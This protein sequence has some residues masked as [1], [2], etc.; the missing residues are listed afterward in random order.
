[1]FNFD[2]AKVQ[3]FRQDLAVPET[4]PSRF[5]ISYVFCCNIAPIFLYADMGHYKCASQ[6]LLP[7]YI[8]LFD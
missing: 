7:S 5:Q 1:M 2:E 4:L 3:C 6:L 8:G